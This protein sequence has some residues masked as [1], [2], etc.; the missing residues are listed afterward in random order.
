MIVSGSVMNAFMLVIESFN[1]FRELK[2]R[3]YFRMKD[4][5]KFKEST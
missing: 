3:K 1:G 2:K 4:A 5:L